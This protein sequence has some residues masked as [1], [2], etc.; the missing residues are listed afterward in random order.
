MYRGN[1]LMFFQRGYRDGQE[2]HEKVLIITNNQGNANEIITSY[3]LKW[4][5]SKDKK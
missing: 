4:L 1:E 5:L 2:I 3:L